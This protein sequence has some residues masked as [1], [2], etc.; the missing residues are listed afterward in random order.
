[1][2]APAEKD[3]TTYWANFVDPGGAVSLTVLFFALDDREAKYK[4]K[5]MVDAQGVDL[6]DG[7]RLIGHFPP[8]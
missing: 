3:C 2:A 1:M 4:A 7:V 6:W 5:A 8:I